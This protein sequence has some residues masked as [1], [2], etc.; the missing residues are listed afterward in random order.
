MGRLFAQTQE[1]SQIFKSQSAL[2]PDYA[3]PALLHRDGQLR[4]LADAL[5]PALARS[6]PQNLLIH[7][8]TGT[9]KTSC[10]KYVLSE[11]SEY[12]SKIRCI[13]INCWE[14]PSK[15]SILSHIAEKLKE[16]LPRRG[17][18]EDEI[19]KRIVDR[20]KYDKVAAIIVLDEIDR[21]MH[22]GESE[23]L[24]GLSRSDENYGVTFGIIGIT[25]VPDIFF[26]LD[27][28]MRSSLRFREM[29]FEK[30]SPAH[31]KDILKERAREAFLPGTYS[32]ETIALCAAHGA[33]NGGD[34]RVA[35]ETLLQAGLRA[36]SRGNGKIE[37]GDIREIID[38]TA[39]A[40]LMKNVG[41]MGENE[42]LLLQLLKDARAKG[43][44]LT[45]GELYGEFN[46]LRKKSNL[47]PISERQIM[48]YLQIFE[49]ARLISAELSNDPNSKSGKT[50]LIKLIR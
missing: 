46:V 26:S 34:A 39:E 15:L 24:Y 27:E 16:T 6:R 18:A 36:D 13:Y 22:K 5:R 9:G 4:E 30:Y 42:R 8:P 20:L 28:R 38:K 2:L 1:R 25:N 43:K 48:N 33:R 12:S 17:L 19:F 14:H 41:I 29:A 32:E 35:I 10:A 31:L 40:S 45:S 3:P 50:K 11:L 21:L 44:T 49:A 47:E 23:V 7:G 37:I